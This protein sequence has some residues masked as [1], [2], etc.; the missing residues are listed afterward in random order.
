MEAKE[1][2]CRTE[3][4]DLGGNVNSRIVALAYLV[5]FKFEISNHGDSS[6]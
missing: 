1:L 2:V 6:R 5:V 3:L 4:A